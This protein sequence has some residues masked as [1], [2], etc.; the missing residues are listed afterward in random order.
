M[1]FL[2]FIASL[3]VSVFVFE[4][5]TWLQRPRIRTTALDRFV[6]EGN[7]IPQTRR[8]T[9]DALLV[10]IFPER[11]DPEKAKGYTDVVTLLKRAGY[12]YDTP[13][14][15]YVSAIRD[16]GL[17]LTVGGA[18][19]AAMVIFNMGLAGPAIAA[20]FIFLG[21]RRP[22][23]RL[24]TLAKKRSEGMKTN[25][26]I[27]MSVMETLVLSGVSPVEALKSLTKIGGPFC[28]LMGL[29]VAQ[30]SR[31]DMQTAIEV[32]RDHLPDPTEMEP[33]LFLKDLESAYRDDG[34]PI[35]QSLGALRMAI[36]RIVVEATEARVA[37]V[38]QRSSLFG[39]FAV[40]G[41][42]LA[43]V[44]PYMGVAF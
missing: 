30:Q 43:I 11:F 4:I 3:A 42:I 35:G 29:L 24:K 15:F 13:G 28:N 2:M 38:R 10:A 27:G 17:F 8:S 1:T 40:L 16:F 25:M 41:L 39:V 44:L 31:T 7:V 37:L 33:V 6:V 5:L 21:L 20:I 22:Y 23:S 36:H 26:L 9:F 19:A 18:L 32:V 14:D 34:R 12:P